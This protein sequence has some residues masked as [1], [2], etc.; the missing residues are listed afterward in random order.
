MP[1]YPSILKSVENILGEKK[2][3]TF[4]EEEKDNLYLEDLTGRIM[5]YG[6]YPKFKIEEF[7][8]GIPIS[9][10]GKLNE[11]GIFIFNDF[12]F[13]NDI[14]IDEK[15]KNNGQNED[16]NSIINNE[17]DKNIIFYNNSSYKKEIGQIKDNNAK[18]IILF[19]SN[20]N[21]G[22][23]L[24]FNN[25][26]NQ[27]II[28]LLIDFIQNQ[29][30]IN[31]ILSGYSNKI[32]RIILVGNS[33]NTFEP[34][35]NKKL[36]FDS[37]SSLKD[38]NKYILENYL[39]FNNFLNIIS[40][41]TYIDVMPS[42][43][44]NDDLKYPQSPLNELLFNENIQN[45]NFGSLKLVSNPYFFNI[46]I[47]SL[48]R[49]KYFIGTSGENVNI[50]KQYSCFDNNIDIMKKNLEWKHLCPIN[51][52]Y[53]TLYSF[54]N[55]VDPLIIN[56]IPDVYFISGTNK[57]NYE[58]IKISNKDVF[59]MSLPDFSK[60]YKCVLYNYENDLIKEID[61]SLNF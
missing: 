53:S 44:S 8:S 31:N 10:K 55:K 13:Y 1:I 40:N 45:I 46:F 37:N 57:L 26:L 12:L 43:D 20:L 24:E 59:L 42:L 35:I 52:K 21:L 49:K 14:I 33:L 29:N 9:I 23:N 54:N 27:S 34:E 6:N 50:I 18:N 38:I 30:N 39:H 4:I 2:V 32:N 19:I 25:G 47:P 36:V 56:E 61:F 28:T 15:E 5:I 41:Y 58:K 22:T 11:N 60:T 16:D 3:E 17:K 48:G 7:V 51:P